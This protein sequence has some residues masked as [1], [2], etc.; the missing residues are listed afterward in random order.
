MIKNSSIFFLVD[1]LSKISAIILIPILTKALSVDDYGLYSLILPISI[2]IV[3]ISSLG[4]SS[5]FSRYSFDTAFDQKSLLHSFLTITTVSGIIV[6][7]VVSIILVIT[8]TFDTID[9][10]YICIIGL[11]ISMSSYPRTYF[12]VE[13]EKIK[14]AIYVI[15]QL[16]VWFLGVYIVWVFYVIS[17]NILLM[18][19][20]ISYLISTIVAY[21]L[22]NN[23]ILIFDEFKFRKRYILATHRYRT[24]MYG[25]SLVNFGYQYIDKFLVM[26]LLSSKFLGLYSLAFAISSVV[27]SAGVSLQFSLMPDF[28]KYL[29]SSD[30]IKINKTIKK[31]AL[32]AIPLYL[33]FQ[34]T[35]YFIWPYFVDIKFV[36]SIELIPLLSVAFIIDAFSLFNINF[37]TYKKE[38]N[39]ILKI[40]GYFSVLQLLFYILVIIYFNLYGLIF[41]MLLIS[42]LKFS[43]IIY[44]VNHK[45]K[46]PVPFKLYIITFFLLSVLGFLFP[47]LV[48]FLK[49]LIHEL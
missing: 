40:E 48:E 20:I 3:V 31:L 11:L 35:I 8:K 38:S 47:A 43:T 6:S 14:F 17:V 39:R 12:I 45:Y 27:R 30:Y 29:D 15:T 37:L 1:V 5:T 46:I 2:G 16:V 33:L 10:I 34:V 25:V 44:V 36:S 26:T 19:M 49:Q 23:K 22:Y 42:L 28:Y 18:V 32:L 7:V 21:Y 24:S 9:S 4:F 41:A 13:K